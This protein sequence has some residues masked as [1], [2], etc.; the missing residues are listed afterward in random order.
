MVAKSLIQ[1]RIALDRARLVA[2]VMLC[3][4][5]LLVV[6]SGVQLSVGLMDSSFRWLSP[7][8]WAVFVIVAMVR[9]RRVRRDWLL[10][11]SEHGSD[12]GKQRSV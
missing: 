9:L 5:I 3:G 10:L 6:G 8:F 2:V 11:E 4:G 1:Q 7:V 12:A